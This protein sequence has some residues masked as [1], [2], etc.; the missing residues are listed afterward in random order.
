MTETTNS[1]GLDAV[2]EM[3]V[4]AAFE[5]WRAVYFPALYFARY[6]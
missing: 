3:L 4:K 6:L 2:N 5:Y 1:A